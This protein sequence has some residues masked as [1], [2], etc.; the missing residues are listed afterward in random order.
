M[1]YL[2]SLDPNI[3]FTFKYSKDSIEFLDVLVK[4]DG[5]QVST[6]LYVKET[7]AHQFLHFDS[8]HPFHTKRAIPYGQA[9]R[10]RRICSEDQFFEKGVSDLKQWLL[11]RGYKDYL[12]DTQIDK[13]RCCNRDALLLGNDPRDNSNKVFLVLTYHPALS[14]KVYDIIN[15]NQNIL[16]I[17]EEHKKVFSE[18][19]MVSFRR[20]KTLKDVLVRSK[21]REEEFQQG[22]CV[23]CQK[24]NCLVDN[25][26][27]KTGTF[28]DAQG[29]RIFN[30]RKGK[31]HY[32]SKYVVYLLRCK[33]CSMQYVGST[34]TKFRE[35][36]NNYKSQFRKYMQRKEANNHNPGKD[37]AQ[38]ALFEHFCAEDHHGM[39]DWSFNIIDQADSLKRVRERES[40]WQY[41][42]DSFSPR[43]LNDREV[44]C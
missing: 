42:L 4:R 26:L 41:K 15:L 13:A 17:N 14:K 43:G 22:S 7:D 2:N 40:F 6:N 39:E 1:A 25:F 34:V 3:Q 28:T 16:N 30:I 21:L 9:L 27:D 36:F 24:G 12:I 35:R 32:N 10:I 20:G 37:I 23:G 44:P 33:S 11:K 18:P 19:P 31:L 38:A 29:D 5:D 8:C